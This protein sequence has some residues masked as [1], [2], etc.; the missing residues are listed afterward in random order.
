MNIPIEDNRHGPTN[1][2]IDFSSDI[3]W[4]LGGES[5]NPDSVCTTGSAC[6]SDLR[7][8][9]TTDCSTAC[10]SPSTNCLIVD[11][12]SSGWSASRWWSP[13]DNYAVAASDDNSSGTSGWAGGCS[14][15]NQ[16]RVYNKIQGSLNVHVRLCTPQ[17]LNDACTY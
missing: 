7:G 8:T 10:V 5:H 4:E 14:V 13:R 11:A 2:G 1:S 17:F 12:V 3:A 15:H 9:G 6:D 16:K